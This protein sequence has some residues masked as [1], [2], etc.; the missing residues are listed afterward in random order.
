M[1]RDFGYLSESREGVISGYGISRSVF[2]ESIGNTRYEGLGA[3]PLTSMAINESLSGALK[4]HYTS[5][6]HE[7]HLSW[8]GYLCFKNVCGEFGAERYNQGR[9]RLAA[10]RPKVCE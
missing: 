7:D 9:S 6:Y 4:R 1:F 3:N 5:V 2:E 8:A 10:H